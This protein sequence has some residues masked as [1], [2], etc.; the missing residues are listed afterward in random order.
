MAAHERAIIAPAR[1]PEVKAVAPAEADRQ[2][3]WRDGMVSFDGE[4]LRT[5]VT[6]INRHNRRQ[7]VIDDPSLASMPVVG[8]FRA[9]DL[10][11]FAAAAAAALNARAT[12]DGDI[13][14][15]QHRSPK[16]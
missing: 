7:I 5:A 9:T 1:P 3:A 4:S 16:N 8:V 2:L 12:A 13:I 6:E 14:R 15:L 11:G 10:D